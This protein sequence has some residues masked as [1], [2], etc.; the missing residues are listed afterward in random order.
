MVILLNTG[1]RVQELYSLQWNDVT[2]SDRKGRIIIK[3]GK[4]NK[5]REVPLNKDA[6]EAFYWAKR[7]TQSSWYTI[8]Y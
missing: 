5:Y 7:N 4:G 8:G 6:R 2:L 3:S 1:V